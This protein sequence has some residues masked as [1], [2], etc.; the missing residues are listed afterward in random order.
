MGAK[1]DEEERGSQG[2]LDSGLISRVLLR[3]S[4]EFHPLLELYLFHLEATGFEF[5]SSSFSGEMSD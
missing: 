2:R 3:G 4:F 5:I 1:R